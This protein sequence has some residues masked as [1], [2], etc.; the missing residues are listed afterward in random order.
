[1]KA[2][3]APAARPRSTRPPADPTTTTLPAGPT[4]PALP[5]DPAP[6][7]RHPDRPDRLGRPDPTT[8]TGGISVV[9]VARSFGDVH[10]VRDATLTARPGEVT[11]LIGPNGSGK[12]TLLLMLASLLRPDAGSIRI[13]GQIRSP[14]RPRSAR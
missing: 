1:M 9:S 7:T 12:T 4:T 11:A 3:A 8:G 10:A 6:G 2:R 5:A 13:D 14:I